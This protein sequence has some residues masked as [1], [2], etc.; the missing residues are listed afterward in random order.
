MFFMIVG[1]MTFTSTALALECDSDDLR[2]SK[3]VSVRADK[4]YVHY[5]DLFER[6]CRQNWDDK[7]TKSSIKQI[8]QRLKLYKRA[9]R[10]AERVGEKYIEAIN[11]WDDHHNHCDDSRMAQKAW[12]E[13][14][15]LRRSY[16]QF[17]DEVIVMYEDCIKDLKAYRTE[18]E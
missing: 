11:R 13:K 17:E 9:E 8:N 16:T 7:S 18:L 5:T 1:L 2:I 4:L 10:L 14:D 3:K 6:S 12:K 15:L